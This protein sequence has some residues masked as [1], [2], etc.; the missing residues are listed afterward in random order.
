[1]T[2]MAMIALG[3]GLLLGGTGPETAFATERSARQI[4]QAP[5]T[6]TGE[7]EVRRIDKDAKKVTLRHGDIKGSLEMSS[8]TMVFNVQ[9]PEMLEKLKVGDKVRFTVA[10]ENGSMVLKSMEPAQ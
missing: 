1:M 4:A 8:M 3:L 9:S 5:E 7:G 6:G 2:R 10:R